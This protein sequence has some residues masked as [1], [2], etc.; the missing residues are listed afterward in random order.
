MKTLIAVCFFFIL[1]TSCSKPKDDPV[2]TGT[3]DLYQTFTSG[4][5]YNWTVVMTQNGNDL[6]GNV[7]I[8]DNSGYA[9]LLSSSNISGNNVTIEWML[10]TYKLSHQ[11]IVNSTYDSMNGMFYSDGIKIGTWLANKR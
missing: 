7:V 2:L 8:S 6:T 11:G 9:L 3:W 4:N 5:T 10:S 1:I